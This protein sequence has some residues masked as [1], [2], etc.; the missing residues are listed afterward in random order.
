MPPDGVAAPLTSAS[1]T[2]AVAS[3]DVAQMR[4]I[5]RVGAALGRSLRVHAL[6]IALIVVYVAAAMALP[7]LFGV[8]ARFS[9]GL[10]SG[11]LLTVNAAIFA[12]LPSAAGSAS[13]SRDS[14]PSS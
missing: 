9:P 6:F 11:V 10:C 8:K 1:S 3:A 5:A 12:G 14:P 7:S 4:W 13:C 2:L